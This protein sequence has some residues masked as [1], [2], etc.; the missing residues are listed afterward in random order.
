MHTVI[1]PMGLKPRPEIK[2]NTSINRHSG[3]T[4]IMIL[5][6]FSVHTT[7]QRMNTRMKLSRYSASGI[8]QNSGIAEMSVEM[9]VVTP[10]IRLDGTAASKIQRSRCHQVNS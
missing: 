3:W 7:G 9:K 6:G 5:C 10:S 8:T 1:E 2:V 4:Q